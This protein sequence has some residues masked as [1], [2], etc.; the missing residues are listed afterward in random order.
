MNPATLA[1][2]ARVATA[3]PGRYLQQL[4]KHFG[5][6]LPA[7]FDARQGSVEFP[8]GRCELDAEA[9]P[10]ILR[11]RVTAADAE[12]LATLEG[13]VARHLER[14]AFREKPEILWTRSR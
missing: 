6:K 9:E 10:G 12:A 14:F 5:H 1:S 11:M 8:T 4:C 7:R 3:V 13:V 2:E